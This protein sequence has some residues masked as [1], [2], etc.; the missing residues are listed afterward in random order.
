LVN[1]NKGNVKSALAPR[2]AGVAEQGTGSKWA[3]KTCFFFNLSKKRFYIKL[4][5]KY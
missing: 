2:K 5:E 1:E 3:I 4:I